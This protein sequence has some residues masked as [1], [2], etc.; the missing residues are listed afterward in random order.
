[1]H[2]IAKLRPL[3]GAFV[4]RALSL[5]TIMGNRSAAR[6]SHTSSTISHSQPTRKLSVIRAS[7]TPRP[8]I[9]FSQLLSIIMSRHTLGPQYHLPLPIYTSLLLVTACLM[10][11]LQLRLCASADSAVSDTAGIQ[12]IHCSICAEHIQYTHTRARSRARA[13]SSF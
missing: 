1:M 10:I 13:V 3:P 9:I 4:L 7:C 12:L 8:S 11:T 6:A 2:C 5:Q